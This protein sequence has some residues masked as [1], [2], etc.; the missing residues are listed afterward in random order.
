MF[1]MKK[2]PISDLVLVFVFHFRRKP[3]FTHD[4]FKDRQKDKNQTASPFLF[5][6]WRINGLVL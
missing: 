3:V 6:F 4:V 2:I 5:S 1:L